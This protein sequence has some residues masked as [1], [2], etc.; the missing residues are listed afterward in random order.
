MSWGGAVVSIRDRNGMA[1]C[2]RAVVVTQRLSETEILSVFLRGA[3]K[4]VG[5]GAHLQDEF[6]G[7]GS[8]GVAEVGKSRVES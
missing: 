2:R 7:G 8:F 6:A 1:L 5:L 4:L 3:A